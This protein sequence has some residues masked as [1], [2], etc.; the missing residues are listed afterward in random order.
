MIEP[1]ILKGFRDSLPSEEIPRKQIIRKLEEVFRSFGFV[2]IDTPV[3]EYENILLGKGGGETDKQ[4]FHFEDN[5]GR[6]VAM[7]F[8]HTVPFARFL[9]AHLNELALPVRCYQI[10][11]V[12][13]GEKPQKG[14][15][16]EFF[17][18]DF[19]IVGAD[20]AESDSEILALMYRSFAALGI[21]KFSFHVAHR[22]L[23]NDFLAEIGL[24]EKSIDILRSVDKLAKIGEEKVKAELLEITGSEEKSDLLIKYVTSGKG[25]SFIETLDALVALVGHET[26]SSQRMREIWD[27]ITACG[28]EDAFV[29][30]PSITRGL[31]YYTGVVYETFL[32]GAEYMGSVCSGGRYNE[33]AS[34]YTKEH[35]PGVGCAIGLDRLIAALIELKSPIVSNSASADIIIFHKPEE[36]A[37]AFKT[38]YQL[39]ENGIKTDLYILP[40]KKMKAQYDY[41]AKNQITKSLSFKDGT[42]AVK[43][44]TNR[45]VHDCNTIDEVIALCR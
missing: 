4:I 27:L 8:D 15:Y 30:D 18:C 38:A 28:I 21:E 41:A 40:E 23:F 17:Q 33:L 32:G 25:K 6:K 43:D 36:T 9:A 5:G 22:G 29:F 2:P 44:L 45:E 10:S 19:D 31:D 1:I 42:Y 7:R 37:L 12:W 13:R 11:K 16:R 26:E 39:R 3:L 35:L 34:L 20:N 14:R 24:T